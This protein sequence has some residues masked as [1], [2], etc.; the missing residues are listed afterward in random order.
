M[1]ILVADD[2]PDLRQLTRDILHTMGMDVITAFDGPSALS[3]ARAERPDLILLDVDMP[4]MNGFDVCAALKT[5]HDTAQIPV[6]MVTAQSAVEDRVRGLEVGADDYLSKPYSPR[7]L[8]ARIETRL[9]AKSEA[10]DLREKQ[11]LIQQTFERY[12]HAS[13]VEQMLKDPS[14]VK[15]GG[16]LQEV[17]VLFA[18]LEGFTALSEHTEPEELLRV[19]N[20][21]HNLIVRLIL[22]HNGTIDKFLGD[23][24][25]ALYNTPLLQPKHALYAVQSAV[26]IRQALAEFH[27]ELAPEQ[28]M[29][30]NF[31]IHTGRAVVG[32]VGTDRIMDFTAVGD[33]VN[34]ASRLQGLSRHNQILISQA[35]FDQVREFITV[36]P[37]GPMHVKNRI[38]AVMTYEV[39]ELL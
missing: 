2:N 16:K 3:T 7:E 26:K 31:G 22:Q 18:D 25:M 27:Q 17:T 5:S 38:E 9:R 39:L 11:R 30:I 24:V 36:R 8:M 13:V 32:N 12:V 23:G 19:L 6:V 35:T 14:Q 1:K 37:M 28:R 15:L 21:Y 20:G 29:S 34:L 33:T 4:G 10:D